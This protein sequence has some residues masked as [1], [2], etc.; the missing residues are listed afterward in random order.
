M[1]R[2]LD[3]GFLRQRLAS[4]GLRVATIV[5]LSAA[6]LTGARALMRPSVS[7]GRLRIGIVDEGSIEA[8]VLASGTVLPEAEQVVSSPID[9]RVVSI[10]R[11]AGARVAADEPILTLDASEPALALEKLKQNLSL[12]GNE[13]ARSRIDLA[14]TLA[15]LGSQVEIKKLQ[16]ETYDSS[17]ERNRKLF[18]EGLVSEEVFRQAK[19][20]AARTRLE[21]L[22][23]GETR[24]LAL[25]SA[26]AQEDGLRLEMDTL[27]KEVQGAERQIRLATARATKAGVVTW[28]VPDAG[29]SVK[30]GDVLARV[31]DLS[32]YRV[33]AT[34]ADVHATSLRTGLPAV[35]SVNGTKLT[36]TVARV[37]PTV[38]N[39]AISVE[40]SLDD[41][42]N[43]V[44]K[45]SLRAEVELVLDRKEM[46]L[47]VPRGVFPGTGLAPAV[48]VVRGDVAVRTAVTF[49]ISNADSREVLAGL[50]PGD[51]VILS[52]MTDYQHLAKVTI[53]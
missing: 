39:G 48:F 10:L 44:L 52:D 2:P 8:T 1:D 46:A 35:V 36:G 4:R 29:A 7:R 25:R 11:R 13:Q 18:A 32:S 47:R 6:T 34:V 28:V 9:A 24:S 14:G 49:G 3:A 23:V 21:L 16:L 37:L 30:R 43:P 12:K 19:L 27:K 15:S 45:P 38:Q 42:S 41:R 33:E 5:V 50:A 31:A 22:Q 40:I 51:A 20:D 26:A 53:R 17:A